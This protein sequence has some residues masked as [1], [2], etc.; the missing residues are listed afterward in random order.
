MTRCDLLLRRWSLVFNIL[1]A[2]ASLL[3]RLVSHFLGGLL[4]RMASLFGGMFGRVV[5]LFDVTFDV[6]LIRGCGCR[7]GLRIGLCE[8]YSGHTWQQSSC[9]NKLANLL[10][11]SPQAALRRPFKMLI[12]SNTNAATSNRWMKPPA[13]LKPKPTSQRTSAAT[14]KI[15]SISTPSAVLP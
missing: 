10:H 14:K 12:R 1:R 11:V 2:L 3:R 4:D 9:K 8:C 6:A 5:R 13:T 15:Q 7:R